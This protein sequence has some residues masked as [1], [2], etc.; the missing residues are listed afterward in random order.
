MQIFE[1]VELPEF[2]YTETQEVLEGQVVRDVLNE[3]SREKVFLLIDYDTKRI[4]IY[5]GPQSRFKIQVFAAILAG[6]LRKQLRLFYR[7]YPLN[8]YSEQDKQFLELLDKPI[9]GGQA[10]PIKKA[11]FPEL[12]PDSYSTNITTT[13][14]NINKA[15]EYIQEFPPPD[16]FVRRFTIIGGT[17][18]TSEEIIESFLK[19]EKSIRKPLKLGRLN[20]GFTFFQDHIYSTRLIVK[21]RQIQG[22]ELFIDKNDKSPTFKIEIPVIRED[23]FEKSGSIDSLIKAFNIPKKLK[24]EEKESSS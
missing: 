1:V 7:I 11:D 6:M 17:I 8:M 5:N 16:S 2:P 23:K 15:L 22:I 24:D 13:S 19:E 20:D 9:G 12:T 14:P 10:K 18:F 4:W 21:E 3:H